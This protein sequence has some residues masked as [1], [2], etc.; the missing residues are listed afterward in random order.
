M[1]VCSMGFYNICGKSSLS[2]V[3]NRT[4]VVVVLVKKPALVEYNIQN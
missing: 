1:L 2:L 3:K 4:S